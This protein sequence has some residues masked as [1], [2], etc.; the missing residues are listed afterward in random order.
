M[1]LWGRRD[2]SLFRV[3]KQRNQG[4]VLGSSGS[5]GRNQDSPHR[6]VPPCTG[7]P[8][9]L[10]TALGRWVFSVFPLMPLAPSGLRGGVLPPLAPPA[11]RGGGDLSPATATVTAAAEQDQARSPQGEKGPAGQAP[12]GPMGKKK[13]CNQERLTLL[14]WPFTRLPLSTSSLGRGKVL[15]TV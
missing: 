6:W 3:G 9:G 13:V 15:P 11:G 7:H 2:Y 5:E 8:A 10:W 4:L 12:A 14:S 1:A